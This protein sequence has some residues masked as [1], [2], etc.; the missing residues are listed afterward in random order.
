MQK[1]DR[2]G[3]CGSG[4]DPIPSILL[5]LSS[6]AVRFRYSPAP[7]LTVGFLPSAT[8]TRHHPFINLPRDAHV[9]QIVFTDLCEFA[10]L[11]QLEDAAAFDFRSFARFDPQRPRDV[12]E[13]DAIAAPQ[14]PGAHR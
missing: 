7:S 4:H 12:V 2:Q 14:P 10:G 1:P 8:E 5:I 3:G 9:V 11:I 6:F 13:R